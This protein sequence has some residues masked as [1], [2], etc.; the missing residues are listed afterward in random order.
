M[1][2]KKQIGEEIRKRRLELSLGQLDLLDYTEISS[3]TLSNLEQGKG[4]I[5]LDTLEKIINIL[6][7][8]YQLKIRN[9]VEDARS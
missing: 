6:G 8:E 2:L 3:K 7:M 9:K 1:S 4:N 5:T